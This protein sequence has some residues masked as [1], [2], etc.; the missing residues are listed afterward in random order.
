MVV[1]YFPNY[2]LK[3]LC[4]LLCFRVLGCLVSLSHKVPC[5]HETITTETQDD[6][7]EEVWGGGRESP[8][9]T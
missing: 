7:G 1:F 9:V 8:P 4:F 3:S 5:R 2:C 6:G